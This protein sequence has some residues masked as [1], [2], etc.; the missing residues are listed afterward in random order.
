MQISD[1]HIRKKK[2]CQSLQC[3]KPLYV[4]ICRT[5]H[6][7]FRD[8]PL[9][10]KSKVFGP[11]RCRNFSRR[12]YGCKFQTF[13]SEKKTHVSHYNAK[14]LYMSKYVARS[15]IFSEICHLLPSP[16]VLGPPAAATFLGGRTRQ[17]SDFHIREKSHVTRYNAKNLYMSKYVARSIIF[18]EI[19]HLLPIPRVL[20]PPAAATFLGERT[21]ANFRLSH[22]RKKPMSVI[23][24]Q[25]T[26]ICPNTSHVS[27][28]FLRY[29]TC[30]QSQ[31]FW[32]P[33]PAPHRF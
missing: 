29:A 33:P 27:Q 8:M 22:P 20:G 30:C 25:K 16:R 12:E 21:G 11:P 1:F 4:Q 15:I 18:S 5:I 26:F 31:G 14:N 9:A 17:I 7:I 3:K 6:N 23:T 19:C 13:T 32:V 10:A 2:P 24:M 28:Y